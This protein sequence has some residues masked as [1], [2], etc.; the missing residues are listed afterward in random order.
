MLLNLS[1]HPSPKWPQNQIVAAL[2]LYGEI[3]D[4]PF[5]QIS[6]H[7]DSDALDMLVEQFELQI[8]K[9]DPTVVHIMGEMT[10]TFRLVK[11]LMDKGIF[12][13]ASTTERISDV[14]NGIKSS[15]FQFVQFRRY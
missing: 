7:L 3:I 1:N 5:P 10:F 14:Q 2:A 9:I 11:K 12:C 8:R 4:L 15:V 13:I 6:P